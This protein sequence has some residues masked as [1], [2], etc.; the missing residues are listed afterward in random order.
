MAVCVIIFLLE[1]ISYF[2]VGTMCGMWWG[3]EHTTNL[4]FPPI[5]AH[6]PWIT[7]LYPY[8]YIWPVAFFVII[9][10]VVWKAGGRRGIT[11]YVVTSVAMYLMGGIIYALWPTTY[12]PADFVNG[13]WSTLPKSDLFYGIV[14][15]TCNNVANIW[16]AF[17]S[18]HNF[19]GA[20]LV[21][22][23]II[24]AYHH[25]GKSTAWTWISILLGVIISAATLFLHQ[26]AIADVILTYLMTFAIYWVFSNMR[27]FDNSWKI[28]DITY[29]DKLD[30][31]LFPD[32]D[33]R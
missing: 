20:Q 14:M 18:Y 26:H 8:Y 5:D 30:R 4:I 22:I 28:M 15:M 10:F 9:P 7:A 21:L 2:I 31:W 23:P 19:W 29:Y 16:G 17:P 13:T 6:I 3:K 27:I 25:S 33:D 1:C 12:T 24:I 32:P 11:L